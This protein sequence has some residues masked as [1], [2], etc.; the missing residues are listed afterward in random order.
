MIHLIYCYII[1]NALIT[2]FYINEGDLSDYTIKGKIGLFGFW[3]LLLG[4]GSILLAIQLLIDLFKFIWKKSNSFFQI[5]VFYML[6]FTKE[7]DN[8]NENE[9]ER[10]NTITSKSH[11]SNTLRDRIWRI[12]MDIVNERNKYNQNENT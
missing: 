2:G 7:L 9:L 11:N 12:T 6:Y 1:L 5:E 3:T 10:I 4:T 8:L